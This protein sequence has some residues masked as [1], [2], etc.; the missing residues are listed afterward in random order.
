MDKIKRQMNIDINI[1]QHNKRSPKNVV[2]LKEEEKKEE[3]INI[4]D[5]NQNLKMKELE[6]K[7]SILHKINL[8]EYQV[9]QNFS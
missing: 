1:K 6:E 7:I 5:I 9:S 4:F 8:T 3:K 2:I